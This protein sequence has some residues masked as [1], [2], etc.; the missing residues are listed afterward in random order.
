[1]PR[2]ALASRVQGPSVASRRPPGKAKD[3]T[4]QTWWFN[5]GI[6]PTKTVV[7]IFLRK[8]SGFR[9]QAWLSPIMKFWELG[10]WMSTS[11]TKATMNQPLNKLQVQP[12]TA[13]PTKAQ[14]QLQ[15][16]V[17]YIFMNLKIIWSF[18]LSAWFGSSHLVTNIHESPRIRIELRQSPGPPPAG[19][20]GGP[21]GP[22]GRHPHRVAREA[23]GFFQQ[24]PRGAL[25][26][27][28]DQVAPEF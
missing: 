12:Q 15:I 24:V 13:N 14:Y 9:I 18:I 3:S 21:G 5:S 6:E 23:Q 11:N 2:Y 27:G 16:N 26:G 4:L 8:R 10:P 17:L 28:Q 7:Y 25:L 22:G 1:M 20:T 19:G